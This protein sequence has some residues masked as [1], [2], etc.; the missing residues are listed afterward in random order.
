LNF[1]SRFVLT[2]LSLAVAA[3]AAA[4][5]K[6]ANQPAPTQ[7]GAYTLQVNSQIVVLDVVVNA[8][9]ADAPVD[10]LTRDDFKVFENGIP[11]TILSFEPAIPP[12]TQSAT[13]PP[14]VHSTTELDNLEPRAPVSIIV[15]NELTT[16]FEDEA[17]A[18]YSL[19]RYLN[20]QGDTLPQPTM[21]IATNLHKLMVLR[22]YTTSKQEVLD[23]LD[24][25][26]AEY[27]WQNQTGSWK[28]EQFGAAFTSLMEVAEATAGHPGHKNVV[29]VGRGFPGFSWSGMDDSTA[30]KVQDLIATC[31]NMLR[32]A[33]ITLYSIDPVGVS[34]EPSD[35]DDSD[36][37]D[38]F[39][40]SINF[41][42]M[43][44][45]TGGQAFHGRNDVDNLIGTSIRDGESFYTISYKP[46]IVSQDPKEF[47]KIRVVIS[48]PNLHATT[49]EGYFAGTPPIPP[50]LDARGKPSPR[51]AFDMGVAAESLMIY[52]GLR[53]MVVRDPASPNNFHLILKAS[54]LTWTDAGGHK[55][56]S[57]VTVETLS[58]DRK[59]K[60]L[61]TA[62]NLETLSLPANP[63]PGTDDRAVTLQVAIPSAAP[64]ARLRFVVR[65]NANGRIGADNLLLVGSSTLAT[66]D[67]GLQA[68]RH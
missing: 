23:A 35:T 47:R 61:K 43:A 65:S 53:F 50:V 13:P 56:T 27:P 67:T 2:A 3:G 28:G 6:D 16:K 11:Q 37:G 42:I 64:A 58:F 52:D 44:D 49:R 10:H 63:D 9:G 14:T 38:P 19:R 41:D 60:L 39:G 33:R 62:T 26:L 25:H 55:Q 36:V 46:T 68:H 51:F 66:S 34:V 20:T 7:N 8:K 59:G 45:A 5:Q 1:R 21:L 40:S 22:D 4:G 32:D 54:D 24:H 31:T 15:L 18:R 12:K 57:E 30:R 17:F 29:W 48:R